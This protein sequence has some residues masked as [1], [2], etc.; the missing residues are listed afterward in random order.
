MSE[1]STSLGLVLVKPA[2]FDDHRGFFSELYNQNRYAKL[3][4]IKPFVQD[5]HSLSYIDVL[6]D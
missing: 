6:A 5:N 2:R 3:G 4:I 1:L